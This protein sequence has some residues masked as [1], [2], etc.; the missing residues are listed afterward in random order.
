MLSIYGKEL[1]GQLVPEMPRRTFAPGV[2]PEPKVL[3]KRGARVYVTRPHN[4]V[5]INGLQVVNLRLAPWDSTEL[6]HHAQIV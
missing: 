5:M 4:R 3:D 1:D 6:L 2:R